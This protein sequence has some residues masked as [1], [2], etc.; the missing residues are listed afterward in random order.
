[1]EP[2]GMFG[3]RAA[4]LVVGHLIDAGCFFA[5]IQQ[6]MRVVLA[7]TEGVGVERMWEGCRSTCDRLAYLIS[8]PP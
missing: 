4:V 1:M 7:V 6:K 5:C 3:I 8:N 2:P